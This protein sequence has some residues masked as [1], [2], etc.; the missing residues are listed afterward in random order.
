MCAERLR[1]TDHDTSA[2]ATASVTAAA[3]NEVRKSR[4]LKVTVEVAIGDRR[5]AFAK[6]ERRFPNAERRAPSAERR[7]PSTES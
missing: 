5:S 4:L 2:V 7:A 3:A 1:R 6:P